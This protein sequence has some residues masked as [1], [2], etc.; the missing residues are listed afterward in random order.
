MEGLDILLPLCSA[1]A[2][3]QRSE[4]APHLILVTTIRVSYPRLIQC[5]GIQFGVGDGA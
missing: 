5:P 2:K 1:L 4:S 3:N